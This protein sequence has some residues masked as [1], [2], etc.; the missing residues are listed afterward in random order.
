MN[1]TRKS[2]I[3]AGCGLV[4]TAGLIVILVLIA[5]PFASHFPSSV[6]NRLSSFIFI[7]S[8]LAVTPLLARK[9]NRQEDIGKV[10]GWTFIGLGLEFIAFPLSLLFTIKSAVSM[11]ALMFTVMVVTYSAIFGIPAGLVSIGIGILLIKK[12]RFSLS[13]L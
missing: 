2:I 3:S 7:L 10:L 8:L 11:G 1:I 13:G 12:R 5:G 4:L 9:L 6:Q